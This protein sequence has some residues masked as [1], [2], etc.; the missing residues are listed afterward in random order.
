[1]HEED[2]KGATL[3]DCTKEEFDLHNLN[4]SIAD[5]I[6]EAVEVEKLLPKIEEA[7]RIADNRSF[8]IR[9]SIRANAFSNA[10]TY[11]HM[12]GH[13][14]HAIPYM[15][16]A[17]DIFHRSKLEEVDEVAYAIT[18]A[19][20]ARLEVGLRLFS[21]A[22][23]HYLESIKIKERIL[24]KDHHTLHRTVASLAQ[25]YEPHMH[26]PEKANAL[27]RRYQSAFSDT[28]WRS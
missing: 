1:M 8:I 11:H 16:K 15:Q 6:K 10:A 4:L 19:N 18:L 23:K 9:P 13:D 21:E 7:M 5:Y 12:L 27:R 22:E 14:K 17:L 3:T 25:L 20:A 24:P 28:P 26:Q 2:W